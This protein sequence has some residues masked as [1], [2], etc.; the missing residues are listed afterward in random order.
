M[1]LVWPGPPYLESYVAALL[2]G[3]SPDNIRGE[4]A[5][6]E[7]L[8]LIA[9]DPAAFFA[10]F[11]DREAKGPP[12]ELPDG[13]LVRRLPGF[14][15]WVWDGEMCGTIGFRWQPGTS[16]LPSHVLGHIG[17]SIVPWKRGLGYAKRALELMLDD[18]RGE[19]LDYVELTCDA[20]N[21]ASQ[22]VITANG[23]E[24]VERFRKPAHFGG[25][26]SLRFRIRL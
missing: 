6:R 4:A 1:E 20:I 12:I 8:E 21:V 23:G 25:H 7:E 5:A 19:G 3:W 17:Y 14:R 26:D 16:A 22:R 11:V 13:T 2:R 24:V 10:R 18:A 9:Q 15:R